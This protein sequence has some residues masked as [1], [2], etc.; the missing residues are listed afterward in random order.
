MFSIHQ[1]EDFRLSGALVKFEGG[2]EIE[3]S[4]FITEF[5]EGDGPPLHIHPYPEVFLV[6]SGAVRFTVEE[7]T[8]LVEAGHLVVVS[9]E[10]RH[11]FEGAS[12]GTN[13]VVSV[14]PSGKV[15]Q[16]NLN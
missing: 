10:T 1:V 11:R 4:I 13:R 6:E 3:S 2:D 12:D 9:E 14:H 5:A 7:E 15:V 16:K 8:T